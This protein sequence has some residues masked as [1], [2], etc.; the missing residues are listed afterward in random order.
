MI[1]KDEELT[2]FDYLILNT[3]TNFS[4]LPEKCSYV[5]FLLDFS[6]IV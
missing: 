5:S 4:T 2:I 6:V 3:S 1:R